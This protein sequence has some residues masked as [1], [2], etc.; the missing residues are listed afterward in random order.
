M[1]DY[2][3]F[4]RSRVNVL[5]DNGTRGFDQGIRTFDCPLCDDTKNRGWI[6]VSEGGAGCFNTG[7]D[8][9]PSLPGGAVEWARRVL[10][11]TSR[12]EAYRH[13]TQ[14][15]STKTVTLQPIAPRGDD[16]CRLPESMHEFES[17]DFADHD[18]TFWVTQTFYEKFIWKQWGLDLDNAIRWKLGWCASG[19]HGMR[20]VIPVEYRGRV[21]GFQTR[22]IVPGSEPKYLTSQTGP[23]SDSQAECGRPAAALLFNYD[24]LRAGEDAVLVEG[25][26]DVMGWH[27]RQSRAAMPALGN[28][29]T[30]L[31]PQKLDMIAAARLGCLVVALDPD[32]AAQARALL[33]LADLRAWGIPAILGAWQGAKDAGAGANLVYDA[34]SQKTSYSLVEH[35][36]LLRGE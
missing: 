3:R 18:N 23:E 29:G 33:Y 28:L 5:N 9:N 36:R 6:G 32:P 30:A 13:L 1:I 4:V 34:S 22:T 15:F 21:V 20:I 35:L 2:D 27:A 25:A 24:A 10:G 16:W 17:P 8:A 12:G 11:L 19:R 7:C 31:T 14:K 26:G